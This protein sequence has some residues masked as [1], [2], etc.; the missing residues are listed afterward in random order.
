MVLSLREDQLNEA[1]AQLVALLAATYAI[2][3][4]MGAK[5]TR[6]Q[7]VADGYFKSESASTEPKP[8]RKML[9]RS[10]PI[11]KK[12]VDAL[13]VRLLELFGAESNARTN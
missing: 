5:E 1:M 3:V 13:E 7:L 11:A 8:T 6:E 2:G 9:K 12:A 10:L 4:W